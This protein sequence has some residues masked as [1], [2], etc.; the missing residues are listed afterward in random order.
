MRVTSSAWAAWP[1]TYA[2]TPGRPPNAAGTVVERTCETIA[3]LAGSFWPAPAIVNETSA[4][5]PS[6]DGVTFGSLRPGIWPAAVSNAVT[7]ACVAGL[8]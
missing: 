3:W 4:T 8:S 7:A 6:R 2:W 5:L 1:V